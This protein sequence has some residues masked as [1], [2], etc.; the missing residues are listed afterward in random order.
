MVW[1]SPRSPPRSNGLAPSVG[2]AAAIASMISSVEASSRRPIQLAENHGDLTHE[3]TTTN[4]SAI[5][6]DVDEGEREVVEVDS[7]PVELQ[8]GW[9]R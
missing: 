6:R 3:K 5:E 1:Y 9:W 8:R 4:F 2:A 7:T